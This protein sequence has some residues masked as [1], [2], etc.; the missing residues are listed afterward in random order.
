MAAIGCECIYMRGIASWKTAESPRRVFDATD[1]HLTPWHNLVL[2]PR[3]NC[4]TCCW[5]IALPV[6]GPTAL[7]VCKAIHA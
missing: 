6:S 1:L 3:Q 7:R 4:C 5:M 2:Q